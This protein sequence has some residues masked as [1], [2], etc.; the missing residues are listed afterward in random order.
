MKLY[1][2]KKGINLSRDV[3]VS[4]DKLFTSI[5]DAINSFDDKVSLIG[6]YKYE[7]SFLTIQEFNLSPGE[8]RKLSSTKVVRLNKF[9]L[10]NYN[11]FTGE[12][13]GFVKELIYENE[14][15]DTDRVCTVNFINKNLYKAFKNLCLQHKVII[16][17]TQVYTDYI[18][19]KGSIKSNRKR[20]IYKLKFTIP[21]KISAL[22]LWELLELNTR[23]F[24]S[25]RIKPSNL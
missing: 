18:Y 16:N 22:P 19:Y 2:I 7:Y 12:H 17:D 4:T 21:K 24:N 1:N 5:S 15:E 25:K 11:T 14:I 10:S 6:N 8:P 9:N 23:E 20:D 13:S 3:N